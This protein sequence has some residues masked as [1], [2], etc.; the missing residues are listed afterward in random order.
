M[1]TDAAR[2]ASPDDLQASIT[3]YWNLRAPSYDA[4]PGHNA[5]EGAEMDA[6]VADLR[7]LLPPPPAEVLDIGAGTG[8]ISTLLA[9]LGYRVTGLDPSAGML[10]QARV[11][12]EGLQPAPV[13]VEGDGHAPPFPPESFDVVA[14]RH[15]LWTLRQ[16]EAAF[17]AWRRVLRPGGRLLAIDSL[18]FSDERDDPDKRQTVYSEDW[19]RLYSEAVRAGLPLMNAESLDPVLTTLRTAGFAD[20]QL[21]RLARVEAYHREHQPEAGGGILPR[22][23]ITASKPGG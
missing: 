12:S 16:P 10:A 20:V 2:P 11:R 19:K 14:N 1:T 21:H 9:R 23:A 22:Y 18:W 6:W 17:A 4:E 15:V 13:Y 3:T 7:D 5:A 8:F